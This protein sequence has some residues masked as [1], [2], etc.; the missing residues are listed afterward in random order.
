MMLPLGLPA[1]CPLTVANRFV[2]GPMV[3]PPPVKVMVPAGRSISTG[4][5]A[6]VVMPFA[7]TTASRRVPHVLRCAEH[8]TPGEASPVLVTVMIVVAAMAGE[9]NSVNPTA[10][11]RG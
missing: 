11:R 5:V 7:V 6:L 2:D 3:M 8:E 1:V 10:S 4:Y 9:L